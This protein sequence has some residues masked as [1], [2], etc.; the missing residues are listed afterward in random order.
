MEYIGSSRDYS[1]KVDL[2]GSDRASGT[3]K[4]WLD[5]DMDDHGSLA[6]LSTN[7]GT[8]TANFLFRNLYNT[9][10]GG[11]YKL[12]ATW[13]SVADV[14]VEGDESLTATIQDS[15]SYKRDATTHSITLHD[16]PN[17][18][19]IV[20][21]IESLISEIRA[22]MTKYKDHATTLAEASRANSASGINM[23]AGVFKNVWA[24]T[25]FAIDNA[26]DLGTAVTTALLAALQPEVGGPTLV[27][28]AFS[29]SVAA[30]GGKAFFGAEG[31]WEAKADAAVQNLATETQNATNK[32]ANE[33]TEYVD[34]TGSNDQPYGKLKAIE[35]AWAAIPQPA[36]PD[37]QAVL[38][39]RDRLLDLLTEVRGKFGTAIIEAPLPKELAIRW[40]LDY[41][42]EKGYSL[43]WD[44]EGNS[45]G[46]EPVVGNPPNRWRSNDSSI[47]GYVNGQDF[48]AEMNSRELW[49]N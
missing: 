39:I 17:D 43:Y 35:D 5:R 32:F 18:T 33:F 19:S 30:W 38:G 9:Y 23:A 13:D 49:P 1:V 44:P 26:G 8:T 21:E 31:N 27:L 47:L 41:C 16:D 7:G 2:V 46:Y 40:I 22:H 48:A 10:T 25:D 24:S 4:I 3:N 29:V 36:D 11:N 6:V 12:S 20:G 14:F 28:E 42:S 15:P 45:T 37:D 34:G